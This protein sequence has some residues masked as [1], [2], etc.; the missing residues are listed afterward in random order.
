MGW[1]DI[2]LNRR[3]PRID[4]AVVPM[5]EGEDRDAAVLRKA[6]G[7]ALAALAEQ[8]AGA[9][10]FAAGYLAGFARHQALK[11]GLD[12][13]A[14]GGVALLAQ[15]AAQAPDAL[16]PA[17]AALR[18][19]PRAVASPRA[20]LGACDVPG[21]AGYLVGQLEALCGTRKLLS[22][23]GD[24]AAYLTRCDHAADRLQTHQPTAVLR[25]DAAERAVVAQA[26]RGPGG[27][28]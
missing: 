17:I 11:H 26:L 2:N 3:K 20:R 21:D 23:G 27:A 12:A 18:L 13:E 1:R 24:V 19:A 15:L 9:S 6:V 16:K 10:A 14:D 5:A 28:A 4:V 8:G 22:T 7:A 25:L